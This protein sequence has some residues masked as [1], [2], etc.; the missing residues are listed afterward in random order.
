[1]KNY[2]LN[3]CKNIRLIY[4]IDVNLYTK[5]DVY[6]RTMVVVGKR[7]AATDQ[8]N[9]DNNIRLTEAQLD[10]AMRQ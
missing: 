5:D 6:V 3:G 8:Y 2:E 9:N 7:F 4:S 10:E 1:M